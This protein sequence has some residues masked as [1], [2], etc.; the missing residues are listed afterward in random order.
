MF[1][2]QNSIF[3]YVC[4]MLCV[5]DISMTKDENGKPIVPEVEYDGF[6]W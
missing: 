1:L 2:A 6:M 3:I 4:M 5:F